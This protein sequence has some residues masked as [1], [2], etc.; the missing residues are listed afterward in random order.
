MSRPAIWALC[1]A[2]TPLC[3]AILYYAWRGSNPQAATYANRI[4]WVSWL[5][6]VGAYILFK[7]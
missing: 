3:G 1:L 4:S 6:W 2:L 5:I 7:R